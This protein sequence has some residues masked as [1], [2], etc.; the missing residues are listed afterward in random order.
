M[1][2]SIINFIKKAL[3]ID[4]TQTKMFYPTRDE[5][6]NKKSFILSFLYLNEMQHKLGIGKKITRRELKALFHYNFTFKNRFEFNTY[7]KN[8]EKEDLLYSVDKD[9]GYSRSSYSNDT[10]LLTVKAV[11]LMDMYYEPERINKNKINYGIYGKIKEHQK[12]YKKVY[13]K[14]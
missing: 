13:K 2:Q 4:R 9:C 8:L 3:K 1:F 5:A 14:A 12:V 6:N 7:Y 10:V 11:K